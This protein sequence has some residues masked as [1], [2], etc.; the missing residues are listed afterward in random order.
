MP[1]QESH[2]FSCEILFEIPGFGEWLAKRCPESGGL[3]SDTVVQQKLQNYCTKGQLETER[4]TC[5]RLRRT[6]ALSAP[7]QDIAS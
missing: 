3:G 1:G 4:G 2:H 7:S 5:L 6:N